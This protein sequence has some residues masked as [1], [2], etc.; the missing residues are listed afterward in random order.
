MKKVS[1]FQFSVSFFVPCPPALILSPFLFFSLALH[2]TSDCI[3][4]ISLL[5]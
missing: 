4:F 2:Y 1:L 3:F 5:F